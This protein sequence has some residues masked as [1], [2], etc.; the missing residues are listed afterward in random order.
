MALQC[1]LVYS[2]LPAILMGQH[3]THKKL[4]Q[5]N[6]TKWKKEVGGFERLSSYSYWLATSFLTTQTVEKI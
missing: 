5:D 4:L 3:I 2:S 6:D 1:F